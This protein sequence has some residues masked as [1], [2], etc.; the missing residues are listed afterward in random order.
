MRLSNNLKS[1]L[2]NRLIDRYGSGAELCREY[3]E[4]CDSVIIDFDLFADYNS[5]INA[6]VND[7][8]KTVIY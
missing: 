4:Y 2:F 1:I 7:Y 6:F 8:K 3:A 5:G